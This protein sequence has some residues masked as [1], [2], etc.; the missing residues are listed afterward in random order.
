MSISRRIKHSRLIIISGVQLAI[1]S[2]FIAVA[3]WCF[4]IIW[5]A[6]TASIVAI[7]IAFFT[8]FEYI[9]LRIKAKKYKRVS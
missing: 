1:L 2:G 4:G 6:E 7:L 9:L 5:L 8:L 3:A